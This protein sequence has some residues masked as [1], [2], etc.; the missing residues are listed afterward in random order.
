MTT[1]N[2]WASFCAQN[3]Q[4]AQIPANF[5]VKS[6]EDQI[7]GARRRCHRQRI[8]ITRYFK[9][10]LLAL[11]F[12]C[13]PQLPLRLMRL[14]YRRMTFACGKDAQAWVGCTRRLLRRAAARQERDQSKSGYI[15]GIA[16]M[17]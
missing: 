7:F 15:C 14:Y 11:F 10:R 12:F 17:P 13:F 2:L 4:G 5:A 9:T 8:K 16:S 1:P 3:R 6:W